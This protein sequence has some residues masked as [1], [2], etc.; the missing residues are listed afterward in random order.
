MIISNLD[1]KYFL[2]P[3]PKIL[4][5]GALIISYIYLLFSFCQ[6]VLITY[7]FLR[8]VTYNIF[9][10][11]HSLYSISILHG[12]CSSIHISQHLVTV[13]DSDSVSMLFKFAIPVFFY[14]SI[15]RMVCLL[16]SVCML[17]SRMRVLNLCLVCLQ[18]FTQSILVACLV[19]LNIKN[20]DFAATSKKFC[21][22]SLGQTHSC[23]F[24]LFLTNQISGSKLLFDLFFKNCNIW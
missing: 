24:L 16:V 4:M 18:W 15:L 17:C 14:L 11:Q 9:L 20:E 7:T 12:L 10:P 8:Y 6:Q 5:I 22:T 21:S 13:F 1:I 3:D 23:Q 19:I 2:C